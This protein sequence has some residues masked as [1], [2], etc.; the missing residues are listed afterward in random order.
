MFVGGVQGPILASPTRLR[1]SHR[2][3]REYI[4]CNILVSLVFDVVNRLVG[5]QY[6]LASTSTTAFK[7]LKK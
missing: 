4:Y 3:E 7:F 1:D 5:R 6:F 2:A